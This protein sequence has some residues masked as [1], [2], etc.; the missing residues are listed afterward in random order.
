M[1]ILMILFGTMLGGWGAKAASTVESQRPVIFTGP[2]GG[3]LMLA[4]QFGGLSLIVVG[5]IMLFS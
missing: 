1:S 5:A 3:L 2:I 4:A